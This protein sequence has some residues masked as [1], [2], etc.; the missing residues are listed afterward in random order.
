[1][2]VA[3]AFI[4][5]LALGFP[6]GVAAYFGTFQLF[7]KTFED[8]ANKRIATATQ[9]AFQRGKKTADAISQARSRYGSMMDGEEEQVS[10]EVEKVLGTGPGAR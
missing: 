3:L 8:R 10:A 4:L 1:L 9:A 2:L 7:H 6:L 5:G